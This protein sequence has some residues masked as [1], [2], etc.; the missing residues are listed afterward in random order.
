MS[1]RVPAIV[2]L[3][4]GSLPAA[5]RV[6]QSLAGASIHALSGRVADA[7]ILFDDFGDTMRR[8]FADDVEAVAFNHGLQFGALFVGY[9]FDG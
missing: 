4:E 5:R 3:G 7:D 8:L 1:G 2:V 9:V 6:Q